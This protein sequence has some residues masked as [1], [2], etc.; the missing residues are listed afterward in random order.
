M[1]AELADG[2]PLVGGGGPATPPP[3]SALLAPGAH[4]LQPA[5]WAQQG[6]H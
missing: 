4:H 2:G 1:A 6:L 3:A 5:H